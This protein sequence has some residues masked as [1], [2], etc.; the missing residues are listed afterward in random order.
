MPNIEQQKAILV[1]SKLPVSN[2]NMIAGHLTDA[3]KTHSPKAAAVSFGSAVL[4]LNQAHAEGA[5]IDLGINAEELKTLILGLIATI[6]VI[7]TA[8]ITVLVGISAFS[9]IRRVVR[10]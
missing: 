8:Y 3:F 10:G 4:L 5:G 9:L 7:G 1:A 6:A 2:A